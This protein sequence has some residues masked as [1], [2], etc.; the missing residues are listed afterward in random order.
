MLYIFDEQMYL[1]QQP[2]YFI[3]HQ[4]E[5]IVHQ[6]EKTINYSYFHQ[7]RRVRV[8]KLPVRQKKKI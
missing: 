5:K 4:T 8:A 3:L 1:T 6:T 2:I 7:K